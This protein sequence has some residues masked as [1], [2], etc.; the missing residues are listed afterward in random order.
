MGFILWIVFG[1]I[2]GWSASL[3]MGTNS[4]Q[5]TL[6]DIV[7]GILGAIVGGFVMSLVGVNGVTGFN[8]YSFVVAVFGAMIVIYIGR[9]LRH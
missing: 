1:A 6:L 3:I 4:G 7:M 8:L 9:M 5:D 2:S